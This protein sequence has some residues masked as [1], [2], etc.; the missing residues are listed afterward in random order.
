MTEPRT[1]IDHIAECAC[2]P[3]FADCAHPPCDCPRCLRL[4]VKEQVCEHVW[5]VVWDGGGVYSATDCCRRCGEYRTGWGCPAVYG[6]HEWIDRPE[7]DTRECLIC[8]TE[9]AG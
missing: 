5:D 2:P 6:A 3:P 7:S 9:V 1:E 4:A 8:G